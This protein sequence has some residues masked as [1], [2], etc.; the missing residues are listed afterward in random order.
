MEYLAKE[1]PKAHVIWAMSTPM[2]D[3]G[4]LA[5][6][7]EQNDRVVER[8]RIAGAIMQPL[9][10]TVNDLYAPVAEHAEYFSN[11]G[12]HF[13]EEGKAVHAAQVA[14]AIQEALKL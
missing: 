9:G 1:A 13:N 2:R 10:I 11:D 3:S 14:Q 12:V 7:G 4:D 6:L 5:Q 8:N